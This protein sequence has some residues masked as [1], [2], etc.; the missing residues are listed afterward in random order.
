MV[1]FRSSKKWRTY[2][3]RAKLYPVERVV[4]SLNIINDD[5]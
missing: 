5:A 3:V 2:L 4:G 1:L